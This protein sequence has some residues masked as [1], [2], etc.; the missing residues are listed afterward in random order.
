MPRRKD[1]SAKKKR[2]PKGWADSAQ[3]EFFRKRIP[4]FREAQV[5]KTFDEFWTTTWEAFNEK[6][7][8]EPLTKKEMKKEVT[9]AMKKTKALNVRTLGVV[10]RR[11]C[12][13]TAF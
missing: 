13:L 11:I 9:L 12:Q 5:E 4:R 7:P 2:G 1:D 10:G 6:W 8:L 3:V